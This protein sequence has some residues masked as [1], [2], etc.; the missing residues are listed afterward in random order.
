MLRDGVLSRPRI[1]SGVGAAGLTSAI[2]LLAAAHSTAAWSS[3]PAGQSPKLIA[4]GLVTASLATL[5]LSAWGLV[6]W[7]F[8]PWRPVFRGRRLLLCAVALFL[9]A[10]TLVAALVISDPFQQIASTGRITAGELIDIG[11]VLG[12]VISLT[13]AVVA[14]VGAW[15]SFV[16]ERHWGRSLGIGP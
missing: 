8:S 6:A 14:A 9:V 4:L 5:A 16:D 7:M 3:D 10:G 1:S 2:V 12:A 13:A 15:E 11:C